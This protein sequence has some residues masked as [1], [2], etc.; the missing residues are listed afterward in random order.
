MNNPASGWF[1]AFALTVMP[2]VLLV[3]QMPW[4]SVIVHL[5]IAVPVVALIHRTSIIVL[6]RLT[7]SLPYSR[8]LVQYGHRAAGMVLFLVISQVI[9][10]NAPESLPNIATARHLGALALI[11]ALTWLGVRCM[12]AIS[13]TIIELNPADVPDNLQARRIQTQTKVLARCVMAIIILL[14]SGT[15]LSTLPILRQIGTSLLASAGVAGLVVGFA[16]KPVLGNLLAGMQI[17][18]T[19]PIR[20]QDVVIV[21][22]EWGH[23]EEITG[24]Y[25]VV[26]IW[27]HRRMIVPLQWFIEH[28]FQN[29]TRSNADILGTVTLWVD[30]RMPVDALRREARRICE[31]A[32]EWDHVLCLAQVVEAGER[33]MQVRI[34]VSAGDAGRC[35]DLRCRVREALVDFVQRE[36]PEYLPRMRAEVA[37]EGPQRAAGSKDDMR[38]I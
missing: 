6:E 12:R 1:E 3:N 16:A 32:P 4:V 15:A 23:V 22:N 9:L 34:L 5:L 18:L 2:W 36:Y 10:R 8:R 21:Q 26:R 33:A 14:G 30:Y 38:L 37:A 19:Q 29:W 24:T 13:H 25:V 28:P 20:L 27:D 17:A 11:A 35:W 7:Y 31:A